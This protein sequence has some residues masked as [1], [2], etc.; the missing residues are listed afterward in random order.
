LRELL[1]LGVL[2][3][4]YSIRSLSAMLSSSSFVRLALVY[5]IL[6]LRYLLQLLFL[7]LIELK[8]LR[9]KRFGDSIQR[10]HG[11][12]SDGNLDILDLSNDGLELL[13]LNSRH[14][15]DHLQVVLILL[16]LHDR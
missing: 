14:R 7:V 8:H 3:L 9:Y 15:L 11:V 12:W 4:H 5:L 10:C 1:Q 13:V 16:L 2:L 6:I